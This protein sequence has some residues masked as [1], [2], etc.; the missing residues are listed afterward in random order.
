M[1]FAVPP[2]VQACFTNKKIHFSPSM[3]RNGFAMPPSKTNFSFQ[4]QDCSDT[5]VI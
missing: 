1:I 2:A 4:V 5:L 3:G